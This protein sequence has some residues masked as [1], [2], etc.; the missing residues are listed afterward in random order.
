MRDR[1]MCTA[2][3]RVRSHTTAQGAPRRVI[4][5]VLRMRRAA[6]KHARRRPL[7]TPAAHRRRDRIRAPDGMQ[8]DKSECTFFVHKCGSYVSAHYVCLCSAGPDRRGQ[9]RA[10]KHALAPAGPH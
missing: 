3:F 9:R 7:R 4:R 8:G 2:Q 10:Q 1:A 6:G 5:S